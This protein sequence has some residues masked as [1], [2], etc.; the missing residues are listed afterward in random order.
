MTTVP[1]SAMDARSSDRAPD[2]S[3]RSLDASARP[4]HKPL[5]CAPVVTIPFDVGST[6]LS[7]AGAGAGLNALAD[8][9]G[10][11]PQAKVSVE[12]HADASGA[13]KHNLFL[14]YRRA[15]AVLPMLA[16]IGISESRVVLSAV[17]S[18]ALVDG[19]PGD[20]PENRRVV[21]QVR[22]SSCPTRPNPGGTR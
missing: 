17:G 3:K 1:A 20:S 21:L 22:G 10:R 15:K 14:S 13:D 11:H 18:N 8:F 16:S 4:A 6:S 2:E 19:L 5:D 9:L 12:G 7:G